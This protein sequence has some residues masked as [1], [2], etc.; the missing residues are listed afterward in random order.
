MILPGR[1]INPQSL[2]QEG[3]VTPTTL[4]Q[5]RYPVAM[6]KT[7]VD[8]K[9]SPVLLRMVNPTDKPVTLYAGTNAGLWQPIQEVVD[10]DPTG[11]S[12]QEQTEK[13]RKISSTHKQ[14]YLHI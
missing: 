6:A 10:L 3:I 13:T 5:E 4:F 11:T 9:T 14:N 1:L 12:G 7:L 8:L 2:D